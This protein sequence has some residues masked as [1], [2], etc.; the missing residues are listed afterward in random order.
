MLQ[1][2]LYLKHASMED[3]DLLY[4]W[5]NEAEC[6]KNSVN[7]GYIEYGDHC[8]W[9]SGK[10]SSGCC[11]IFICMRESGEGYGPVGQV[12]VDY[13]KNRDGE[14]NYS[15]GAGYRCNGYGTRMLGLLEEMEEVKKNA[16]RLCAMVKSS[17]LA[18]QKC[19]EKLGYI[20]SI[21][22]DMVYYI[23]NI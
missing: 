12:R 17:N 23:K 20:K 14:I 11:G 1:D 15:I 3:A 13:G 5:R 19:F 8:K 22:E 21:K 16:D 7:T 4:G 6:R 9:L 10:L 2:R 18:S